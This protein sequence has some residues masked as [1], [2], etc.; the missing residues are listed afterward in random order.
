MCLFVN[1]RWEREMEEV[2]RGEREV[3]GAVRGGKDGGSGESRL[4]FPVRA[5][6][7]FLG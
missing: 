6:V 7:G 4:C 3:E 5:D 1:A 2:L